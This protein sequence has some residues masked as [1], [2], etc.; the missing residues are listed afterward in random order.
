MEK[1]NTMQKCTCD[2]NENIHLKFHTEGNP[3]RYVCFDTE[4][5]PW[6][7][8]NMYGVVTLDVECHCKSRIIFKICNFRPIL[9]VTVYETRENVTKKK[10]ALHHHIN[11]YLHSFYDRNI[12]FRKY[13]LSNSIYI[14][15]ISI[16][17]AKED[18]NS[19]VDMAE[20]E[21]ACNM[22]LGYARIEDLKHIERAIIYFF[23]SKSSIYNNRKVKFIRTGIPKCVSLQSEHYNVFK[24]ISNVEIA[25]I[26]REKTNSWYDTS[27]SVRKDKIKIVLN[28]TKEEL[29]YARLE[30]VQFIRD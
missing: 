4:R 19:V 11:S 16:V 9:S 27:F 6:N 15:G 18:E 1:N 30:D 23:K 13:I 22:E 12:E 8:E 7:R 21:R 29:V 24:Q 3:L 26:F 20:T 17:N 14:T 2:P 10:N 5:T 28:S 25:Y